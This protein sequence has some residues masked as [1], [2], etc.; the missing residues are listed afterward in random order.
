M[1]V[2]GL[3]PI[4]VVP[5]PVVVPEVEQDYRCCAVQHADDEPCRVRCTACRGTGKCPDCDGSGGADDVDQCLWCEGSGTCIQG[6][7][8][9]WLVD[10]LLGQPVITIQPAGGVL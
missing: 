7:V 8:D 6:C 2:T 5:F 3:G 4:P 9:G 10:E 1:A